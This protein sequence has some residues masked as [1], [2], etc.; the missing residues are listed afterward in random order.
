M[1]TFRDVALTLIPYLVA[2]LL[3]PI[4]SVT[5]TVMHCLVALWFSPMRDVT[6][7]LTPYLVAGLFSYWAYADSKKDDPRARLK[8]I[9]V[10]ILLLV[11]GILLAGVSYSI[12]NSQS[13][14]VE[15]LKKALRDLTGLVQTVE[16]ESG[17]TQQLAKQIAGS[18]QNR[19]PN[20][21]TNLDTK[22]AVNELLKRAE[23]LNAATRNILNTYQTTESGTIKPPI[24]SKGATQQT[25]PPK[26]QRLDERN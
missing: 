6:L 5:S 15:G 1:D 3:S 22:I 26:S 10:G 21:Q 23:A 24:N 16:Q 25:P 12:S 14:E 19:V 4:R 2:K 9:S 20:G 17:A 13:K 7:A 11:F 18:M 8:K